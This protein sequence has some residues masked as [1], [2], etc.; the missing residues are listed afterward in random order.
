MKEHI[1][2]QGRKF[3]I[4]YIKD[5]EVNH[6]R[7]HLW[8]NNWEFIGLHSFRVES[9]VNKILGRENRGLSEGEIILTRLA[10]ILHDI[11][12]IIKKEGHALKGR[13]IVHNWLKEN[14]SIY[15]SMEE[16]NRLLYLIEKHSNKRED[17]E[18][19]CLK[20]LRDAD[21]LDEIGVL[22]I[23][24][25]SNWIDKRDP[26][27]FQKLQDRIGNFEIDFID[28]G[29][30][31]LNTDGAKSILKEKREFIV[32]FNEQLKDEL[33]GTEMFGQVN[34]EDYFNN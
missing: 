33:I 20:V 17:E 13:E 2:D 7:V 32:K 26:Y 1:L 28:R 18:D 24:M 27:F 23:F 16:P 15:N 10:T 14:P 5:K 3:L 9:Y 6:D 4:S 8:R 30:K 31:L 22:S 19:Y 29:F 12:R 21:I 11:G 25:A 34:L